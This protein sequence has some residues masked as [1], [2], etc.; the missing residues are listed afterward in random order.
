LPP[1][2]GA[3]RDDPDSKRDMARLEHLRWILDRFLDGWRP[4]RGSDY[5]RQRETLVP[6]DQLT[7]REV[8]KDDVIIQTSRELMG[9]ASGRRRRR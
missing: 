8:E 5:H 7:N 2:G 1:A 6:F 9:E 3:F 4:G